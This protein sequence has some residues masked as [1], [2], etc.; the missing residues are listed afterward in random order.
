MKITFGKYNVW[1]NNLVPIYQGK[2]IRKTEFYLYNKLTWGFI[3]SN[4]DF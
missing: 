4:W 3:S 2:F 1:G